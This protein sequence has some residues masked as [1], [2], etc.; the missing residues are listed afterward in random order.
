MSNGE[1]IRPNL[2]LPAV[3]RHNEHICLHRLSELLRPQ[4][5]GLVEDHAINDA[6]EQLGPEKTGVD[7]TT[8]GVIRDRRGH[9]AAV[10]ICSRPAAPDLV[11][12]GVDNAERIRA[13]LGPELGSVILRPLATGCVEGL[14]YVILPWRRPLSVSR[15]GWVS[16]RSRLRPQVLCWLRLAIERAR[17]FH[18]ASGIT[19]DFMTPLRHL[20]GQSSLTREMREA[21]NIALDRLERGLWRPVHTF[22]HNDLWRGN[23]LLSTRQ[24]RAVSGYDFEL[25]DWAGA[26]PQGFGVYDLIR[27]AHSFRLGA[28][29]LAWEVWRQG[30]ALDCD[31]ENLPGH[32]LAS[33]GRLHLHLEQFPETRYRELLNACWHTFHSIHESRDARHIRVR[34]A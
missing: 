3:L 16:Q 25:I 11:K 2:T 5:R 34:T 9:P 15:L 10:V 17:E 19:A 31:P 30:E 23:F 27:F 8:K 1:R 28:K 22:D 29:R 4:L 24:E 12:R 21:I 18:A 13:M 7:S 6:I 32:L 26:N 20:E 33:F 14:S